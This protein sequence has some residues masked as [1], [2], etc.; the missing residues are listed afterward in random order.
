MKTRTHVFFSVVGKTTPKGPIGLR[1]LVFMNTITGWCKTGCK[2]AK[3][4]GG[5]SETVAP[6]TSAYLSELLPY[7]QW[8]LLTLWRWALCSW[9]WWFL[10]L[11]IANR[12]WRNAV[13]LPLGWSTSRSSPHQLVCG[14]SMMP[15]IWQSTLANGSLSI[16]FFSESVRSGLFKNHLFELQHY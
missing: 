2:A 14:H 16:T 15:K 13:T 3:L 11:I 5:A 12:V 9:G 4:G 10:V 1:D 6:N 7:G 8:S